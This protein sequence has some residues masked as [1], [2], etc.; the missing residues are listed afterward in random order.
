MRYPCRFKRPGMLTSM[1]EPPATVPVD[2]SNSQQREQAL[3]E[4]ILRHQ[5]GIDPHA[6]TAVLDLAAVGLVNGAWRNS[7]VEDWHAQGRLH[8]SDMLRVNSYSTWRVRQIIRRWRT[9]VGLAAQSRGGA[10]NAIDVDDTDRLAVRIWRWLVNPH[11]RL[12]NGMT[13]AELAGNDLAEYGEHAED[14][15]DAFA[16]TA[17]QRGTRY[18]LWRAA[19]H[20]GLACRHWWG[21]PT[22]PPL[23]DR[24]L[25]ALDQP[26]DPPGG[27]DAAVG[28][29]LPAGP[30]STADRGQLRRVLLRQPWDLDTQAAQWIVHAGIG[31]PRPAL[32]PLPDID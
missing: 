30:A 16:A 11:R 18:A 5:V 23:V 19:S 32:P 1:G 20:G 27:T 9:E 7:P 21:T 3:L 26:D 14:A 22:W 31:F 13:L 28:T 2:D 17:A 8:D 10:L 4:A 29:Q 24:F 15:L 6:A 12:P 25:Y